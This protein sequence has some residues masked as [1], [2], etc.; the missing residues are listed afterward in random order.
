M[1]RVV[2]NFWIELEVDGRKEK[3]ATGPRSASGGFQMRVFMREKGSI[4]DGALAVVGRVRHD[5]QL[6]IE[7]Y[8]EAY[9]NKR[10][11]VVWSLR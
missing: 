4:R 7:V 11:L 9:P 6:V 5:G 1:P 10:G 3:V 8:D 2:R